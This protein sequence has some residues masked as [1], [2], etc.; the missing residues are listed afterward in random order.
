MKDEWEIRNELKEKD[1]DRKGGRKE[2]RR[3]MRKENKEIDGGM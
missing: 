2:G 3:K 1:T